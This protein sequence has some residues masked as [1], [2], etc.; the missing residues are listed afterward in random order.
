M[1]RRKGID[2]DGFASKAWD[3]DLGVSVIIHVCNGQ[4]P[5]NISAKI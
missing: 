2:V 5:G 1:G 4:T 3:K